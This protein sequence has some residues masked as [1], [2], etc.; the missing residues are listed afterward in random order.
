MNTSDALNII[1]AHLIKQKAISINEVSGVCQYR[2]EDGRMCAFGAL[3]PDDLYNEGLEFKPISWIVAVS[4]NTFKE[5]HLDAMRATQMYHDGTYTSK[6]RGGPSFG[7]KK[8]IGGDD[9]HH[10]ER[11]MVHIREEY[12][13]V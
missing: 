2:C 9:A 1:E 12:G 10:P 8:W 5:L 13:I 6:L 3:I 11:L 7:Y 4:G